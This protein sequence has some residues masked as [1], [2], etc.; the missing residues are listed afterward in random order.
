MSGF[1][2]TDRR[3]RDCAIAADSQVP[4]L[5]L[6]VG[7]YPLHSGGVAVVRTL[8][9]LGVPVYAITED[10]L[11]PSALSRYCAGHFVWRATGHEEP[12]YL[13]GQLRDLGERLGRRT[14]V[15][16]VDDEAAVLVAEHADEL[17]THF[18][19]PP[20]EPGL[21]RAL[22]SKQALYELC[23][24]HDVPVPVSICPATGTELAEFAATAAFPV[25]VKNA[26]PWTRRRAPVVSH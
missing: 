12:G 10:R 13:A 21:P 5:L 2:V 17:S 14:V 26:G 19:F 18:I 8:G 6:K 23:R 7:R 25:V 24:Q 11:T 20:I 15:V 22:S 9:R 1:F 3:N 16:P 4:A